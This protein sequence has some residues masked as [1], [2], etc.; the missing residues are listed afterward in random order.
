MKKTKEPQWIGH[1]LDV[2]L[3]NIEWTSLKTP[4][5]LTFTYRATLRDGVWEVILSPWLHEIY[6][7][8]FDGALKLPTYEV[9]IL[10]VA[11]NFEEVSY[12]GF[13][14]HR[15]EASIEGVICGSKATVLFRRLAPKNQIRRKINTFTGEVT[16]IIE[17]A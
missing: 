15:L 12:I 13:D 4:T 6:G 9:N 2:F 8:K 7:G 11:K 5:H 3:K 1:I 14:T 10:A 16:K 17:D